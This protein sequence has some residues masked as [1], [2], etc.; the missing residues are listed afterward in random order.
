VKISSRFVALRN[1]TIAIIDAAA[2]STPL[3]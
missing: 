3:Q 2:S 1:L